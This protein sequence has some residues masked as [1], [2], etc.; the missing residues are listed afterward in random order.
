MQKKESEFNPT[1][2]K[3][4]FR[5]NNYDS[6]SITLPKGKADVIKKEAE[7]QECSVSK[8]VRKALR[9]AFEIDV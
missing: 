2:Y 9:I 8:L 4:E 7:Y 3:S 1:K 5:K 6:I